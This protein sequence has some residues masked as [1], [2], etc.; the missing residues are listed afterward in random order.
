MEKK[1]RVVVSAYAC[2]PGLGSEPE[3]GWQWALQ[4]ARFHRVWVFTRENN[5]AAIL[6]SGV[7]DNNP[8][9]HFEF[10]DLPARLRF[11][12]KGGRGVHV[13]YLLWQWGAWWRAWAL[14]RR[15]KF[16]LCH[17]IT[18]SAMYHFPVF[19]LLPVPFVWGPV[20]GGEK[21]PF[22][23][24]A[25]YSWYHR[26]REGLRF[27]LAGMT[28]INPFFYWACFRSCLILA[29][30]K[31]TQAI[32]PKIFQ[33]RVVL[34]AQVG[35]PGHAA[36]AVKKNH[37][38][39]LKLI[40]ASRHVYWK[41]INF[42]LHAFKLFIE[43]ESLGG[44][45]TILGHGPQTDQLKKLCHGLGLDDYVTFTSYLPTRQMVLQSFAQA[46]V[47]VYASVLECAGYVVLE[48]LSMGTP[49]VCLDLPG[50]GEIVDHQCGIR[51]PAVNP[52]ETIQGLAQAMVTL[53]QD[54]ERLALLTEGTKKR[55]ESLFLWDN[56]GNRLQEL[57]RQKRCF[58]TRVS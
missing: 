27:L 24:L 18:F 4:L 51:V 57:F 30:T 50:P 20:G 25:G 47:F 32:I 54:R 40:T 45:L 10:Y 14:H 55:V 8:N 23:F 56:K 39:P 43:K 9:L 52:E 17:H 42:L 6:A 28:R 34:E 46:D 2:E 49:V 19:S 41:G 29:A 21:I 13:Y 33:N 15:E 11:W 3:V 1:L 38:G 35:M 37:A 12:K 31:E 44:H 48:A 5:R 7:L 22:R 26:F 16:D 58:I 36:I 53:A